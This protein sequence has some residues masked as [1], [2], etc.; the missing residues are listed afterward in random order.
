MES[1]I[2]S[3]TEGKPLQLIV[4]FALPL[5]LGNVFQQLYTVVDGIVVGNFLSVAGLAAIGAAD[6]LYWG[7]FS[8]GQGFAQGFSIKMAQNFGATKI[9][10]LKE[11]IADSLVL[12]LTIST[13]LI[14]I[15]QFIAK[16]V[17]VLLNTPDDIIGMTLQYI[18]IIFCGIGVNMLY[19]LAAAILRSLG[20]SKTPL[21]AMI[22]ASVVNIVLDL[23]FI[24][25]FKSGIAGA[26][27]ATIVG[28][29]VSGLYC[30]YFIRKIE[31]IKLSKNDF[32]ASLHRYYELFVLGFPMAFQNGIIAMGGMIVQSVVN[33][34]GTSFIGGF[35]ATNKL[36][37]ILEIAAVSFGY[38]MVTYAG[39]NLGAGK[40]NRIREGVKAANILAVVTSLVISAI[41]I[42]FGK[43]VL[44]L[45][46]SGNAE[47][48]SAALQV[49]YEF[50]FTMSVL[51]FIL[52][53]LHVTR[54][55]IQGMG[56][57]FLPMISGVIEFVMRISCVMYLPSIVGY[58]GVFIAE[59]AAWLG[60]DIV[61]ITSYFY[62]IKKLEKQQKQF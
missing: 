11:N 12:T 27:I 20:D 41:M 3:M 9:K 4:A 54:S 34:Y 51:L 24:V 61:L 7:M 42:I 10:E 23:V 33:N 44:S 29:V 57:T 38:S 16:P 17:L 1:K 53:I 28:Q 59:P 19:N 14:V 6:W 52:Y 35:T 15:G 36:Y 18:R 50:L 55:T 39:Q 43:P 26:A 56:N 30:L 60:A 22:V 46:L 13:L 48:V 47:E 31:L 37:G 21:N 49:G 58:R 40:Y 5:M 32:L 8:I 45:F 25:I 62:L 2:K